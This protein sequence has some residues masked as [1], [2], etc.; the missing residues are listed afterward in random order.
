MTKPINIARRNWATPD[1]RRTAAFA[2][3]APAWALMDEATGLLL[4]KDGEQP[5]VWR[6]KAI[7]ASIAPYAH[8]MTNH[9]FTIELTN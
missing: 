6:T 1:G 3:S 7:A 5:S 2:S 4:S 9:E 8:E